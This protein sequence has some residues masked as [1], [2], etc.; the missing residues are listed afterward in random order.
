M[1]KSKRSRKPSIL[2]V[3]V[4]PELLSLRAAV[5]SSA[6]YSV[7]TAAD[8]QDADSKI[9]QGAC[10]VLLLCYSIQAEWRKHIVRKFRR[11]CPD[12][13]IVAIANEP[14]SDAQLA[15]D[16]LV[17]GLE[18]AEA[19]LAAVEQVFSKS[20]GA[21]SVADLNAPTADYPE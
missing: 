3:G 2:S 10:G 13:R 6:G 8:P 20:R 14:A 1:A 16:H 15:A 5:L 12:G 11:H 18:G 17:Y 21:S 19:L 4:Y 7:L 9:K